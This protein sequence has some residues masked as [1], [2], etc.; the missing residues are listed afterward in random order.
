M[1][2]DYVTAEFLLNLSQ[3]PQRTRNRHSTI[4]FLKLGSILK[5]KKYTVH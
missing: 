3:I 5:L 4:G 2:T 1:F